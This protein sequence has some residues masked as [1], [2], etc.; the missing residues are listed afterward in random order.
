MFQGTGTGAVSQGN[1]NVFTGRFTG[2][3]TTGNNNVAMGQLAGSLTYVDETT[4]AMYDRAGNSI[5]APINIAVSNT[6][7]IG[8]LALSESDRGTALG[9]NAYVSSALVGSV[10]LGADSIANAAATPVAGFAGAAPVGVV[11]VGSVGNER[12]IQNVAAGQITNK[13]TDAI[14]GSQLYAVWQSANAAANSSN[15]HFVSVNSKDTT[16]GNYGN[17]GAKGTAATAIGVDAIAAGN[18]ATAL[19]F[20]S[21]ASG[22]N[23]VAIGDSLAAG[24]KA[25][26]I[27]YNANAYGGNGVAMGVNAQAKGASSVAIGTG[28]RD[29]DGQRTSAGMQS[30]ALGFTARADATNAVAIGTYT[31]AGNDSIAMGNGADATQT[32]TIAIGKYAYAGVEAI[33]IGTSTVRGNDSNLTGAFRRG[34]TLIGNEAVGQ[35]LYT[36]IIGNHS[37]V[38]ANERVLATGLLGRQFVAQNAFTNILGAYNTVGDTSTTKTY[39]GVAVTVVGAA[40]KVKESNGALVAGYGNSVTNSYKDK[41]DV[42][43]IVSSSLIDNTAAIADILNSS[44]TELG[45]TGVIGAVNKLGSVEHLNE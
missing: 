37:Q 41:I 7:A 2:V 21:N 15:I 24:D 25:T 13:S 42:S 31:A 44:N 22:L 34:S 39:N 43:G 30:V 26:G 4:G 36:T 27:G 28:V 3:G 17:D 32:N 10:A 38:L 40:N 20:S 8:N 12:Q 5:T 14:N 6:V 1:N 29:V 23:S 9:D 45:Q 35:G 11:S 18:N 16:K 19:G 33:H